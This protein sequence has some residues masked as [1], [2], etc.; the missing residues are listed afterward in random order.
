MIGLFDHM[1]MVMLE[2]AFALLPLVIAFIFFQI[3]LLKLPMKR[4]KRILQGLLLTYIGLVLFLQGVKVGYLPVGLMMGENLA[5]LRFNWIL[6]PIGLILG[7][8]TT[9]A[10]PAVRVLISEVEKVT[11][12]HINKTLMLYSLCIGVAIAVMLSMIRVLAGI[13]LLFFLIPLYIT[14]FILSRFVSSDFV[15]IAFDSGGVATGPMT[16]TFILSLAVGAARQI[17]GR[18]VLMDGFGMV[19]LVAIM[20]IVTIL[21]LGLLYRI[22]EGASGRE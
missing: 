7:F 13:N 6:I 17:E 22:K 14:A 10:E 1:H 19:A 3:F 9:L 2:V 11:G 12:G 4:I 8:A 18:S 15:A 21:L 20:P 16:V 5:N